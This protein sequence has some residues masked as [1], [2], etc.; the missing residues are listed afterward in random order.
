MLPP[1]RTKF[2]LCHL[3][4]L[5]PLLVFSMVFFQ[6]TGSVRTRFYF[7]KDSLKRS[8]KVFLNCPYGCWEDYLKSQS[9]WANFV[10]DQFV[11]DVNLR[12]NSLQ[13]GGGG[14]SYKMIFEGTGKIVNLRDTGY[15]TTNGIQTENEER[16]LLLKHVQ[17]GLVRYAM[18][19]ESHEVLKISS[20]D[21]SD[22]DEI[23][24]GS[25]PVEDPYNAWVYNLILPSCL[26]M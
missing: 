1:Y 3:R 18:Q 26:M 4:K 5:L 24:Q 25:N 16:D 14:S 10:Q 17:L 2:R 22:R 19:T 7:L 23:G 11:A 6:V 20:I 13:N 8:L 12:I 21:S 15:F 9:T